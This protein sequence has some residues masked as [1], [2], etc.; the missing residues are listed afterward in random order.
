MKDAYTAKEL[1]RFVGTTVMT[2]LRRAK[3]ERWPSRPRVGAGGGFEWLTSN[4]PEDVRATI[5]F[6]EAKAE[7]PALPSA[8]VV[9]P[10][11]AHNVGM[12]RFQ[13]VAEW[14]LAIKKS[15]AAKGKTTEA[16]LTAYNS[17]QFLPEAFERLGDV[18]DKTLYRWDK[19]LRDN[20][21]DY[22]VLCDRRG[23]WTNGGKKGLG[24]I[25]REAEK[26]FLGCWLT[27]NRP[28]V[29]LAYK[30][31]KSILERQGG[32]VPSYQSVRRFAQ[33]FDEHH[34]DLVVLKREGEKALKDKVGPYIARN[35]QVLAVGDV[36]F[37][38]GHVLNFRCLHPVTGKPFRPTLICWFDWRSRMPVGW[39]I[40]P[41]E[42]T[43]AISSALHM[44]IGTLGQY[45]RCVYIDN[46][47]AFRA[48]Y[49]SDSNDLGELNGLYARL[50]IAVQYSRPYEARTK[51]IERWFRTFDE[52]CQ[53][54]LP[55]YI[56]NCID[57]K[58][59]WTKRN[60][61]YHA[62]THN[63]WTPTLA[64][65]SEIFR[66]FVTW[67]G[68]QAHRGT[69]NQR[70]LDLLQ[71]GTGDGVDMAELDRHF[72]FRQQVTP[73]RC[74]FTIS[75]VRFECDAL[76]GLNKPV[77]A[78]FSW[79]DMSEIHVH[80]LDGERLG[81]A[82]PTEAL[83]PLAR[84]FG[85]ELDLQKIRQANKRQRQLKSATMDLVKAFDG[86]VRES[87]LG[88]LPWMQRE[89]VPLKAVPRPK[90]LLVEPAMDQAEADRLEELRSRV[91]AL[92]NAA[93][94]AALNRPEF[95]GSEYE[96]YEWCFEQAVK[97]GR[98]LP[99]DD[100]NFMHAYEASDEFRTA[101]GARFEQ[102][103][104]FYEHQTCEV[105]S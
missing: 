32:V 68:Q 59:A 1:S 26:V 19:K 76:Y 73:K 15:K 12:A 50:G 81:T 95:F 8:N 91:Q 54:L 18:S 20:G 94:E 80:T 9:I 5:T 98:A 71:A 57:N 48:K 10:D 84:V 104:S 17:G 63:D 6:Q 44:A 101:T 83:H 49:F 74:G 34:H 42:D 78:M 85:D 105:H 38:D 30:A 35:D 21:D 97:N 36:L 60:E 88:N 75:G 45:P 62:A 39:E 66:L 22:R 11:W 72:L 103:R 102:L 87:G 14:R 100:L 64:E 27:P 23:K 47:K 99:P 31:T 65:A 79:A 40:M 2:I 28:S 93:T 3:R 55:S 25:G 67:Y 61:A 16:F 41:T 92:P 58:P 51:I 37:C 13:L 4:L 46:G 29:A 69:G 33:R 77:M 53:R 96:R 24:Q 89:T 82:R 7:P 70:P 52:Q 90:A 86:E 56:G 43:V